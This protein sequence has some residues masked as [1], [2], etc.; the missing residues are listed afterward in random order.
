MNHNKMVVGYK[1]FTFNLRGYGGYKFK[2]GET[3]IHT[4]DNPPLELCESGFHF[5]IYAQDVLTYYPLGAHNRYA[6]VEASE[7]IIHGSDKSVCSCIT[8]VKEITVNELQH[9]SPEYIKRL[10]GTEGWYKNGVLHRNGDLPAVIYPSGT[11]EWFKNGVKHRD[12]G[13]P[14][15]IWGNGNMEWYVNGRLER[16]GGLPAVVCVSGTKKWYKGGLLHRDFD[17]PAIEFAHGDR[18]W[19]KNGLVHRDR[20]LPAVIY[21]NGDREYFVDGVFQRCERQ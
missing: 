13:M 15:I 6:I 3:Y 7:E 21:A 11:T 4:S 14:A 20:D 16:D 9:A 17:L 1:G 18:Q 10:D 5:C 2:I 8:I 12:N 19:C